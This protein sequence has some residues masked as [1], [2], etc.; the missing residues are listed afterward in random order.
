MSCK[1]RRGGGAGETGGRQIVK[2]DGD[3]TRGFRHELSDRRFAATAKTYE[4]YVH[5]KHRREP[6]GSLPESAEMIEAGDRSGAAEVA[7]I[8]G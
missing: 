6:E 7:A 5:E 8:G 3:K 1:C 2:I 4:K